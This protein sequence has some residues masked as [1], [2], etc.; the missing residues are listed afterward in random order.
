MNWQDESTDDYFIT[1]IAMDWDIW[2]EKKDTLVQANFHIRKDED[3]LIVFKIQAPHYAR[4]ALAYKRDFLL[5]I[6]N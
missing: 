2:N 4:E 6:K 5:N 1:S 3:W